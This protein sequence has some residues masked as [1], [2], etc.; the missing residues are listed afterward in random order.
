[1]EKKGKTYSAYLAQNSPFALEMVFLMETEI[2]DGAEFC[3]PHTCVPKSQNSASY[4]K[5]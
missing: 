2:R 4:W 5:K 1:M 3:A